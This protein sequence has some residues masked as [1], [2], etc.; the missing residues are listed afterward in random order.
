MLV[1]GAP[2]RAETSDRLFFASDKLGGFTGCS[3]LEERMYAWY[4]AVVVE[5]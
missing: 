2:A 5:S 1:A 3:F 4:T